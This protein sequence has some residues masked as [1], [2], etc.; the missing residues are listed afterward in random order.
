M[1]SVTYAALDLA[2]ENKD[3]FFLCRHQQWYSFSTHFQRETTLAACQRSAFSNYILWCFPS[4]DRAVMSAFTKCFKILR[5]LEE[6]LL[7]Y[8]IDRARRWL[9]FCSFRSC[10]ELNLWREEKMV[11]KSNNKPI[12]CNFLFIGIVGWSRSNYFCT[13]RFSNFENTIYATFAMQTIPS[14]FR[15]NFLSIFAFDAC[16]IISFSFPLFLQGC[17]ILPAHAW[18]S[19]TCTWTGGPAWRSLR[20]IWSKRA[21]WRRRPPSRSSTREPPSSARRSACWK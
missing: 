15:L 20:P 16:D 6:M 2:A 14:V 1:P 19:K 18:R 10:P 4:M 12:H 5:I 9:Y 21:V 3:S 11:S 17:R 13:L 7:N 8:I